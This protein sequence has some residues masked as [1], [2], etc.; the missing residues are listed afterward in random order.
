MSR[1][2]FIP[3]DVVDG[4]VRVRI[5]VH[6]HRHLRVE[7]GSGN[8]RNRTAATGSGYVI[9]Q[10]EPSLGDAEASFRLEELFYHLCRDEPRLVPLAPFLAPPRLVDADRRLLIF[11]RLPG[12]RPLANALAGALEQ[13]GELPIAPHAAL[14]RALGT[15]HQAGTALTG[16]PRLG[17]SERRR[18]AVF[19]LH[20]P[21]L[22]AAS[23]ISGAQRRMLTLLQEHSEIGRGL[24]AAA[25][26]WVGAG[27]AGATLVHGDVRSDN[28]LVV[29]P[30]AGGEAIRLI[31]WEL[32]RIGDP[33][34]DVAGALQDLLV[35][36]ILGLPLD[37]ALSGHQRVRRAER[38]L[39]GLHPLFAAFRESYAE[40][41]GN[42]SFNRAV[43]FS[44][45]R[46]L[47]TAW[48]WAQNVAELPAP[49][50]MMLQ[51]SANVLADPERAGAELYGFADCGGA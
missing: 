31:D 39:A 19:T 45:V 34:W 35:F 24:D 15:L 14:G 30:D 41:A 8:G 6:R 18:P 42:E 11:D 32:L 5:A 22:S 2:L 3:A 37:P 46:L 27:D 20:R 47:R 1:G 29:P 51:V 7:R 12:A 13:D 36:W 9:K 40:I 48:E 25:A 43:S 4:E 17:D 44:A 16:S 23:R 38:P 49:A 10:I 50:V 26:Q 28:V 21:K 33:A